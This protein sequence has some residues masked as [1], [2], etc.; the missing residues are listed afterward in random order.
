MP[1]SRTVT[2]LEDD[3][4]KIVHRQYAIDADSKERLVMELILTRKG[5][6]PKSRNTNLQGGTSEPATLP[7]M[8]LRI[9]LLAEV[10]KP[11]ER[12]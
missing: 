2:R 11:W 6:A 7:G 9:C 5:A 10:A 1:G 3:G 12:T 8:P 4:R